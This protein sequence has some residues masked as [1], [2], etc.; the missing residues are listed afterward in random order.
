MYNDDLLC[1]SNLCKSVAGEF[2]NDGDVVPVVD[3][4]NLGDDRVGSGE[5]LV[6]EVSRGSSYDVNLGGVLAEDPGDEVDVVD[7]AVVEDPPADLQV[8][9]GR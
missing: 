1:W 7:R 2:H 9:Q 5:H 6:G 8:V 3:C 4:S